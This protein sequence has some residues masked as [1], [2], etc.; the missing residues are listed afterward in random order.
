MIGGLEGLIERRGSS[1]RMECL[2]NFY[3]EV[4]GAAFFTKDVADVL[5]TVFLY[6]YALGA[7]LLSLIFLVIVTPLVGFQTRRSG[8]WGLG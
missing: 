1:S 7:C 6:F 2:V 4:K 3:K 8:G 5:A